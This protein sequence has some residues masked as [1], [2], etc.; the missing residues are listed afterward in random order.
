MASILEPKAR[1]AQNRKEMA[2]RSEH[3]IVKIL[4]FARGRMGGEGGKPQKTM[5]SPDR[6]YKAPTDSTKP[7]QTIQ[8]PEILDKDSRY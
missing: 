2:C 4:C 1:E 8:R 3:I 5:Q 7:Q 6:L